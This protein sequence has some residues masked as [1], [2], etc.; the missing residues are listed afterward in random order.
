MPSQF[1]L[2]V[3][4]TQ[5]LVES[6]ASAGTIMAAAFAA[7][8][9]WISRKSAD[10]SVLAVEEAR[11]SRIE[12]SKPRLVLERDFLD[13][14]FTW[15]HEKS[16]NGEPIF[17][18]RKNWQDIEPTPPRFSLSNYGGGAALEVEVIFDIND[19]RRDI[20]IPNR[21][22]QMGI[23]IDKYPNSDGSLRNIVQFRN[24]DGTGVGLPIYQRCTA[25]IPSIAPNQSRMV[26]L[27]N[28]IMASMFVRGLENWEGQCLDDFEQDSIITILIKCHTIDGEPYE[29]QFRFK[30]S[31]FW[32]GVHSP[33]VVHGHCIELPMFPKDDEP[34][35]L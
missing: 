10:A 7:W 6:I 5:L 28:H 31:P 14:Q 8:S 35:L 22:K 18:A 33:L 21:F 2:D 19:L 20:Q 9:A 1:V 29:T 32:G 27:P 34:R 15:P 4:S 30:A 16:L 26:D 24:P 11:Y 13:F 12:Q 17:L 25:N 3:Q 23:V